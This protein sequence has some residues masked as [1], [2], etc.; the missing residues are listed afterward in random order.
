MDAYIDVSKSQTSNVI[1]IIDTNSLSLDN[2]FLLNSTKNNL[3]TEFAFF[4]SSTKTFHYTLLNTEL[5][6][7][8]I[9]I[10]NKCTRIERK[11][12]KSRIIFIIIIL[13]GSFE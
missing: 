4:A 12:S 1:G 13:Q 7:A 5:C 6:K 10:N 11:A 8:E 2:I 3:N 9:S